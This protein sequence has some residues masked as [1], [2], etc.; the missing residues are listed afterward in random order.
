MMASSPCFKTKFSLTNISEVAQKFWD[1]IKAHPTVILFQGEV[2]AGKTTLIRTICSEIL[3]INEKACSPT[4]GIINEYFS[5]LLRQEIYHI[6]LYRL[7]KVED[8]LEIGG[9]EYLQTKNYCFIEWGRQLETQLYQTYYLVDM[10]HIP[11]RENEREIS[12]YRRQSANS[13]F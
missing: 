7:T 2:G 3:D 5:Q 9:S 6:D 10:R 8:F 13:T 12:M 11:D 1:E 4:F